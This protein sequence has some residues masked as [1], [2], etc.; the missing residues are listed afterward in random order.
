M[1]ITIKNIFGPDNERYQGVYKINI[2]LLRFP[3]NS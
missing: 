3:F 1:L 2:Y